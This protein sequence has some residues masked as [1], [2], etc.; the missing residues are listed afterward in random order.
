MPHLGLDPSGG[1]RPASL[2]LATFNV[3]LGVDGWG[4]PFDVV[5]ECRA[6]D[7]DVLVMQESWAPD[8]GGPS[9]ASVVAD[10]LGY[11][12]WPRSRW[13]AAACSTR[14][15]RPPPGGDRGS[16]QLAQLVP[17]RR[18]ALAADEEAGTDS[19]STAGRLGHGRAVAGPGPAHTEVIPLGQ[20]R[21]DPAR[22]VV[23]GCDLELEG[24]PLSVFGTHMSHI[25]HGSHA[26]YRRL[27][28][29]CSP[30]RPVPRCWP[31]T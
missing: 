10:R 1:P 30:P 26:Q 14:S 5:G 29:S 22:R 21:R 31:G 7:A 24:G 6:L 13:P 27:G 2:T 15:R 12:W 23:I 28:T 18:R 9:T 16:G 17:P 25:T 11:R 3:H 19:A 20:L 4:R 8:G